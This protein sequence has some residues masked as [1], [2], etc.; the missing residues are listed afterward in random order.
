MNDQMTRDRNTHPNKLKVLAL[1]LAR[2][3]SKSVPRKNIIEV[4]GKPLIA[5]TIQQALTSNLITRTIVSTDDEEIAQISKN[6]GAEV[7]FMR[8]SEIAQDDSI[9]IE[10]FI[11]CLVWLKKNENYEP[12]LIVH[13]RATGPVRRVEVIDQAID[14]MART[15]DADSLRTVVMSKQTPYKM[16]KFDG[17]YL[18]PV[19]VL[20]DVPEAHSVSRQSLPVTYWQNGYVD[21]IRSTT[22]SQKNSMVGDRVLGIEIKEPVFDIDYPDDVPRVEEGLRRLEEGQPFF[23]EDDTEDRLPV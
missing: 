8:P 10:A 23:D 3:G 9:D 11:H 17:E 20:P 22:I 18:Q 1:I 6:W 2:G 19:V 12:D 14:K 16:W 13:L 15:T 5:Y 7:P 21:V 4:N